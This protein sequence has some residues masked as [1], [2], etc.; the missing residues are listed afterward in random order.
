MALQCP[1]NILM[2]SKYHQN[3]HESMMHLF[4]VRLSVPILKDM[5]HEYAA[6]ADFIDSNLYDNVSNEQTFYTHHNL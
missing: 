5:I 4:L 6:R 1:L 3:I 2:A